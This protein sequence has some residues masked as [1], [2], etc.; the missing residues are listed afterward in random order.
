MELEGLGRHLEFGVV[1]EQCDDA[2]EIAELDGIDES[3]DD[4]CFVGR[5]GECP[6]VGT[7]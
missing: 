3:V 1:G 6:A 5:A 2:I 7:P 4:F